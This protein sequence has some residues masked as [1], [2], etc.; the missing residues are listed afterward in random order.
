MAT[1]RPAAQL[2]HDHSKDFEDFD[3]AASHLAARAAQWRLLAIS[4]LIA[5]GGVLLMV[6][7]VLATQSEQT[8]WRDLPSALGNQAGSSSASELR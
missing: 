7:C 5:L 8:S 6:L 3:L 1:G 2:A 4:S